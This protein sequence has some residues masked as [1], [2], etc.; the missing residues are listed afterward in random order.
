MRT[1]PATLEVVILFT[2]IPSPPVIIAYSYQTTIIPE[3]EIL[4]DLRS[5]IDISKAVPAAAVLCNYD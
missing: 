3:G 4:M 2:Q 5:Q 1:Q